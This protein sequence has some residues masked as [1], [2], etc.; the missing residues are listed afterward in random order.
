MSSNINSMYRILKQDRI[1]QGDVLINLKFSNHYNSINEN[2]TN[3]HVILSQDC[4]L[5]CVCNLLGKG[6]NSSPDL[7]N[8]NKYLPSILFAPAFL[9]DNVHDGTYLSY[10]GFQMENKGKR[11][12]TK[13]QDICKNNNLRYHF[14]DGCVEFDIPN[15]IIDFKIFYTLPFEF[16]NDEFDKCYGCSLNELFREDLSNRFFNYHSRIGLP[17][18]N[19]LTP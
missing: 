7:I 4:D 5:D 17:E 6:V 19:P 9:T 14:L 16:V 11:T 10:L 12:K 1:H 18:I 2:V 13:W 3:Y 15:L 8:G